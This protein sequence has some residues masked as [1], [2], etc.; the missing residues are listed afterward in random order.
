M[1]EHADPAPAEGDDA[2]VIPTPSGEEIAMGLSELPD[3]KEMLE[4]LIEERVPLI[5]WT[6][7]ARGYYI[8]GR[9]DDF[10]FLLENATEKTA[11]DGVN[12]DRLRCM[13]MLAAYYVRIGMKTKDDQKK[14]MYFGKATILYTTADKLMMYDS[15]HLIGRAYFCLVESQK[16]EQAK[17]QF[18]YVINLRANDVIAI[19]GMGLVCYASGNYN[20]AL[21]FFKRALRY[22]PK[23]PAEVRLGLGHCFLK[24]KN[25][26]KAFAAFQRVLNLDP[27]N[28]PA[29]IALATCYFHNGVDDIAEQALRAVENNDHDNAVVLNHLAN[30]AF[31]RH[32]YDDAELLAWKAYEHTSNQS[33]NHN[34][35]KALKAE[36]AYIFGRCL[37]V[38]RD[39]D[40]AAKFYQLSIGFNDKFIL[41]HFG[42]G[43]INLGRGNFEDAISSF[44]KVLSAH[45]DDCETL[46]ILGS[47]Y[48]RWQG[49]VEDDKQRESRKKALEFLTKVHDK[50][51][52]DIEVILELAQLQESTRPDESLKKYEKALKILEDD[53]TFEIPAEMYSN[54]GALHHQL[55]NYKE[56]HAYY[57]KAKE[58]VL[59]S[60]DCSPEEIEAKIV[61]LDYNLGRLYEAIGRNNEAEEIFDSILSKKPSY[62]DALLRIG[63]IWRDRGDYMKAM[64][65]FKDAIAID[66]ENPIPWI[67]IANL[68]MDKGETKLAQSSYEQVLKTN[69]NHPYAMIGLGDVWL[70]ALYNVRSNEKDEKEKNQEIQRQCYCIICCCVEKESK[71]CMGSQWYWM[72]ISASRQNSRCS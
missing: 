39:Y 23:L 70:D 15:D 68:H 45:P 26:T 24:L 46:K 18:E 71:K 20:G 53:S 61:T 69:K 47:I 3:V 72:C 57:E 31:L 34:E 28:V 54:I 25:Y 32:K 8:V 30:V 37:H 11:N 27:T 50:K 42:L 9:Y 44:E 22:N 4:L 64:N 66:T 14:R 60:V 43:Q 35:I 38:K 33:D 41:A 56:A 51:P 36:S 62:T 10:V 49:P 6:K 59:S 13:D 67:Y 17:T 7:V 65:K 52:D 58:I 48:A 2:I 21:G 40:K 12:K 16:W 5:Y 55:G 19:I 63:C 1:T 29:K